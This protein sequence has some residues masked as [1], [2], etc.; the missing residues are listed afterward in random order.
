MSWRDTQ[1]AFATAVRDPAMDVPDAVGP[2]GSGVPVA[3]F[4]VYRNNSA[5]SLTEAIADSY[6]VVRALVGED[7]FTAMARQYVDGHVPSS[8][9]LIHYGGSFADFI[10]AFE[11]AQSLPFLAD[12]AR[13]EWAWV[14]AYHAKDCDS[15]NTEALQAANAEALPASRLTLHPSLHLIQSN[16]PVVSIWSAHQI[17][18]LEARQTALSEIDQ[19]AEC[20]VIVR[21]EFEVQVQLVQPPIRQLLASFQDGATLGEA[22][23][24]LEPDDVGDFGGMLS[25]IF[26]TGVVTAIGTATGAEIGAAINQD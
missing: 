8:P 7:F 18:D 15:I 10:E 12:I 22:A 16:W 23:E 9:V 17:E 19:A 25:Y 21:P 3:R 13:V 20:G 4:N 11:P 1:N 24:A 2:R 26:S 5:V 6:P 14:Q